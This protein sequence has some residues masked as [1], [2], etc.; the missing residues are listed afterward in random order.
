MVDE[1]AAKSNTVDHFV[2]EI[3]KKFAGFPE[4]KVTAHFKAV[5]KSLGLHGTGFSP[6]MNDGDGHP[7]RHGSAFLVAGYDLGQ[8]AATGIAVLWETPG[9]RGASVQD[10]RLGTD[11]AALG[12]SLRAGTVKPSQ[13]G[14]WIRDN[15]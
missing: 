7:W 9:T 11:A 6:N 10:V 4:G 5:D 15:W 1:M 8:R 13:V 2:R 12:A 3:G 14:Q